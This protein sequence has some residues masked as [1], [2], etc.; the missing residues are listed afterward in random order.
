[1][2]RLA[3]I[4]L[5]CAALAPFA[6]AA[7][8]A[9][10]GFGVDDGFIAAQTADKASLST[11]L[12]TLKA[13]WVRVDVRWNAIATRQPANAR[14]AKDPAY[15]WTSADA[16]V[17]AARAVTLPQTTPPGPPLILLSI[18]GTPDW[19]RSDG[20]AGG[21]P[22]DPAWAPRRG[23][24]QA[25][26]AAVAARYAKAGSGPYGPVASAIEI[27]PSPNSAAGLRPQRDAGRLIAPALFKVLVRVGTTE[28]RKVTQIPVISGGL[29]R[30]DPAS[31]VDTPPATFLK[32]MGRSRLQADAIGVRLQPPSG[33][34]TPA[35]A[36]NYALSDPNG[37]VAGVDAAFPGA[38]KA[39]WET[40]YG[41]SG[42]TDPNVQNAGVATL[43]A[44]AANPRFGLAIWSSLVDTAGVG[45]YS[46][47]W[48]AREPA[49]TT[50]TTT[51]AALP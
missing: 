34:E 22:G 36:G 16:A 46:A 10:L 26:V 49:W 1:M 50:W 18:G 14:L 5:T 17:A 25:F 7:A 12:G 21:T 35:E 24:F 30:I 28:I 48:T 15:D 33:V 11:Q 2:R 38:A 29:A 8:A 51:V 31:T 6:P 9:P 20:G 13:T 37:I 27:W 23:A 4:L 45:L 43:L 19:A 40:G 42:A 44:A 41:L 39:V 3:V 47:P 32:A